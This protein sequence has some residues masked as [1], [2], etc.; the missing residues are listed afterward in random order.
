MLK[1]GA[2]SPK[3]YHL[4]TAWELPAVLTAPLLRRCHEAAEEG[5]LWLC[6]TSLPLSTWQKLLMQQ[7]MGLPGRSGAE[8]L[9][10]Q[11]PTLG[12]S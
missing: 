10:N 12:H 2:V 3:L 8:T 1:L 11:P 5:S 9:R 7:G 6:P 4:G